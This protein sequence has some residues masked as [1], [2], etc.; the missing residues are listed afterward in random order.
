M[1][2]TVQLTHQAERDITR[3]MFQRLSERSQK[4]VLD[5][6]DQAGQVRLV[7]T[8]VEGRDPVAFDIGRN[9]LVM[10]IAAAKRRIVGMRLRIVP[11]QSLTLSLH[12]VAVCLDHAAG[13]VQILPYPEGNALLEL[14]RTRYF[15][16]RR[17]PTDY[18]KRRTANTRKRLRE[19]IDQAFVLG[20]LGQHV[21]GS[22]VQDWGSSVRFRGKH[23]LEGRTQNADSSDER[24]FRA[25]LSSRTHWPSG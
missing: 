5:L 20:K 14:E 19:G 22:G 8:E 12:L 21:T 24:P 10:R 9:M 18:H 1:M 11:V 7:E 17:T 25:L 4:G 15:G 16:N 3:P 2:Y 13:E 23:A 6:L